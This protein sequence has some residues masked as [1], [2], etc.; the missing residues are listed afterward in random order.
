MCFNGAVHK[1]Y[2]YTKKCVRNISIRIA[3]Y[4]SES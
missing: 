3:Y 2:K 4:K 1:T